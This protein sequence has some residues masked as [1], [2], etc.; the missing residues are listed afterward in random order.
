MK[1]KAAVILCIMAAGIAV[2]A[3]SH[4]SA[5]AGVGLNNTKLVLS[6]GQ[7][8]KLKM[9]GRKGKI[10]WK[11]S[12]KKVATVNKK[13]KVKAVKKESATVTAKTG[14]KKYACRITVIDSAKSDRAKLGKVKVKRKTVY[15]D[16]PEKVKK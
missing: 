1:K 13:G 7:T 3:F 10:K 8:K 16:I 11:S 9:T 2:F 5:E 4:I 6:K 14:K 15:T 12:N